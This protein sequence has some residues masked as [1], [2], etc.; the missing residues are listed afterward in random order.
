MSPITRATVVIFAELN[1][2]PRVLSYPPYERE[3]AG[4]REPW[5]RGCAVLGFAV[6]GGKTFCASFC[7]SP[8]AGSRRAFLCVDCV[9]VA[10]VLSEVHEVR[11]FAP[12]KAFL[13]DV[14]TF[15][16]VA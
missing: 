14:F 9:I 4:R 7:A 11:K 16:F 15:F 8:I 10:G 12:C 1:L 6:Q 2:V 13:F 5:E 3:R